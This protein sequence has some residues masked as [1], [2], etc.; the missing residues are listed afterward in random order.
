MYYTIGSGTA[1]QATT[2]GRRHKQA[3]KVF[4]LTIEKLPAQRLDCKLVVRQRQPCYCGR[5][6]VFIV[7]QTCK[8]HCCNQW[9]QNVLSFELEIPILAMIP[10][11]F[12]LKTINFEKII[13]MIG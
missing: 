12:I 5:S 10:Y 4:E 7:L 2:Q 8:L 11:L 13:A 6:C 1:S 9:L 3:E